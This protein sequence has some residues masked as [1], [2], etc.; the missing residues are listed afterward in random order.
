MSH[1]KSRRGVVSSL[2]VMLMSGAALT[3]AADSTRIFVPDQGNNRV[4]IYNHPTKS[5]QRADLVLGQSGFTTATSGTSSTAMSKPAAIA[6]DAAGNLYV[7]DTGNC[8]VLQF[9][10]PFVDGEAASVVIGKPDPDTSCGSLTAS[11][12][13]LGSTGGLAFDKSGALWVADAGNNRV[14]RF[15]APFSTGQ[16]A[17]LVVGQT[18][19]LSN[20][21]PTTPSAA[22]LCQPEGVAFGTDKMLWIADSS[23]HRVLGYKPAFI[24][25]MSAIVELGHPAATAFTSNASN[26]GGASASSLF[27]PTG[28]GV[29]PANRLWVVDGWNNRILRFSPKYKNGGAAT[30]VLGQPDFV[31][32]TAN[33]GGTASAATLKQPQGIFIRNS[34]DIWIGDTTNNRTLR[35]TSTFRNNDTPASLA[36][37]QPDFAS[38]LSNQGN[39][40][41]SDKTQNAP[42]NAGPSIIALGVLGGLAGTRHWMQRFKKRA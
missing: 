38:T 20:S 22:S 27:G 31:Q 8:R 3:H 34:G 18:D 28:I 21:C 25:G 30:V 26:D 11:Q 17:D 23:D 33:Q 39:A 35:Y 41:P 2:A 6:L 7:S 5:G 14:M 13:N 12:T 42:F 37:G 1:W 16:P 4:L 10:Q 29:D 40:D 15:P 19:F 36:L 9:L 32:T 24:T